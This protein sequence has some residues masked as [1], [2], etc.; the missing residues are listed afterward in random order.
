LIKENKIDN[1]QNIWLPMYYTTDNIKDR[2]EFN[3]KI[4]I[5]FYSRK[6]EDYPKIVD[7]VKHLI[8]SVL[9]SD[10][11]NIQKFITS[12]NNLY[13]IKTP[14]NTKI[15]NQQRFYSTKSGNNLA[16]QNS[17]WQLYTQQGQGLYT[18]NDVSKLCD[19]FVKNVVNPHA[20]QN[21]NFKVGIQLRVTNKNGD[22]HSASVVDVVDANTKDKIENYYLDR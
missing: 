14:V 6:S 4:K 3:N 20:A 12:F 1:G 16:K 15:A 21:Q 2:L 9:L 18:S 19:K 13:V 7:D 11:N 5:R 8:R 10:S 22:I 17:S